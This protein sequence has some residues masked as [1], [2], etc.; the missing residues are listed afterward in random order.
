[1]FAWLIFLVWYC[2]NNAQA[3][4]TAPR[5]HL[6]NE[7][8]FK[9][10]EPQQIHLAQ[11]KEDFSMT[12]TWSTMGQDMS[13]MVKYQPSH[14]N[15]L[16]DAILVNGSTTNFTDGGEAHHW[17]LIHRVTLN[18]L[19]PNTEYIYQVGT[20]DMLSETFS[21]KT[22]PNGTDWSPRFILYGDFG[23]VNDQ[24]MNFLKNEIQNKKTDI[25]LHVGDLA[26]DLDNVNIRTFF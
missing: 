18:N 10:E 7:H 4:S 6:T 24:S 15:N 17:Q 2:N 21:F 5:I 16:H 25:I 14:L 13:S 8:V 12:V 26:Y 23:L 1:M 9:A 11:G 3:F 19:S 20:T 22:F